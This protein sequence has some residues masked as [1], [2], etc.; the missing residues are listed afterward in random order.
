MYY[1][2]VYLARST[3]RGHPFMKMN[4]NPAELWRVIDDGL[5]RTR[6]HSSDLP[7]GPS[8]DNLADYFEKKVADIR[9][10]TSDAPT[11][12]FLD[13]QTDAQLH[14][15]ALSRSMGFER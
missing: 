2:F 5:Y 14:C 4:R 3:L 7:P 11:P 15:F 8:A 1:I 10:A 12:E 6:E 9:A 13:I